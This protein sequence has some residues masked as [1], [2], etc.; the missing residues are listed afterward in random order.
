MIKQL[1]LTLSFLALCSVTV[2]AQEAPKVEVFGGYSYL[3]FAKA[4]DMHGGE[5]SVTGNLNKYFGI[6]GAYSGHVGSTGSDLLKLPPGAVF[7]GGPFVHFDADSAVH[8]FL[9]GPKFTYRGGRVSPYVH[10]LFGAAR[11]SGVVEIEFRDNVTGIGGI[12]TARFSETG[13]GMAIGGGL[14]VRLTDRVS[15]RLVQVDYLRTQ[16]AQDRAT[17]GQDNARVSTGIVFTFGR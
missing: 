17:D 11:T 1:A 10:A 15:L 16:L 7:P 9:A 13:F 6:E 5:V 3:R 2:S 12:S 14:D 8:T 4:I